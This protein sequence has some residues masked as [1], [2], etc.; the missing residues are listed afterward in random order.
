MLTK[1]RAEA[2]DDLMRPVGG[3]TPQDVWDWASLHEDAMLSEYGIL[4]AF[5][6]RDFSQA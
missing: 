6:D 3:R 4:Q 2:S 1:L 5:C